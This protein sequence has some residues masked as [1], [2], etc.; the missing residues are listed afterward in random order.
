MPVEVW[1]ETMA[2]NARGPML[3]CK[4]ALKPMIRGGGGSIVN[5]SS[6]ESLATPFADH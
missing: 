1:D 3:V 2:V 6:A 5:I 4:H